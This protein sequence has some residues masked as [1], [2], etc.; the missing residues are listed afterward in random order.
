MHMHCKSLNPGLIS[1]HQHLSFPVAIPRLDLDAH[2]RT[3][4]GA[5]VVM[6]LFLQSFS[7]LLH[8][9]V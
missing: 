6:H 9:L 1:H 2:F 7:A 3:L 8:T 5:G 4:S